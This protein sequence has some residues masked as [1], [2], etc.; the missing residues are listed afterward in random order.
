VVVFDTGN[1]LIIA[2]GPAEK[3]FTLDQL[4]GQWGTL[5]MKVFIG[6]MV[7]LF[8]MLRAGILYVKVTLTYVVNLCST[9]T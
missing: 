2:N 1:A 6:V 8:V 5:R 9:L 3:V 4:R 7:V